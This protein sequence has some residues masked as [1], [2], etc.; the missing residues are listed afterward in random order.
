MTPTDDDKQD[1]NTLRQRPIR[2]TDQLWDDFGIVAPE[3]GDDRSSLIRDYVRWVTYDE[4]V[5]PPRRPDIRPEGLRYRSLP[6]GILVQ[7]ETE[8]DPPFKTRTRFL[9][10]VE[11]PGPTVR[12]ALLDAGIAAG[13]IYL[14]TTPLQLATSDRD[15]AEQ[16]L[17]VLT[18]AGITYRT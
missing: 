12:K 18:D 13:A 14:D 5:R 17:Q 6:P 7:H 11:A 1:A 4:T 2:F 15:H 10:L 16:I 8:A 3:L 9:M